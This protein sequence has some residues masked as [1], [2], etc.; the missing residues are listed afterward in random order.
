MAIQI[1]ILNICCCFQGVSVC[2]EQ[3][4]VV[5][6][7]FCQQLTANQNSLFSLNRPLGRFSH[8]VAM[9]ICLCLSAP[10][11]NTHFWLKG[12]SLILAIN[13]TFFL[14][15]FSC[16]YNFSCFSTFQGFRNN[17][18]VEHPTVSQPTVDN[19]GV[20][21]PLPSRPYPPSQ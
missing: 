13:D 15:L 8:R 19:K 12:V 5:G 14:L 9:S 21:D 10:S 18:I 2:L 16:F 1:P 3:K 7:L 20:S 4:I 6:Y 11:R 17:P